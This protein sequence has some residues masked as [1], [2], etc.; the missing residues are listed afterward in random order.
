MVLL[1]LLLVAPHQEPLMSQTDDTTRLHSFFNT[2]FS[3]LLLFSVL[4]STSYFFHLYIHL[5]SYHQS[6]SSPVCGL[7]PSILYQLWSLFLFGFLFTISTFNGI[8]APP[9]LTPSTSLN[10]QSV[11]PQF[12]DRF[13][14]PLIWKSC[15]FCL[16][17]AGNDRGLK[18]F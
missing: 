17:R 13:C 11:L 6:P 1:A 3:Y 15:F 14:P 16:N 12:S 18:C 9:P 8:S 4:P 10:S 2:S 5:S 7:G